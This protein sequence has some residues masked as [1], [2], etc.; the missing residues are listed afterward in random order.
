MGPSKKFII[1]HEWSKIVLREI[2]IA[3]PFPLSGEVRN[4]VLVLGPRHACCFLLPLLVTLLWQS[5]QVHF[6]T[7]F[8]DCTYAQT[9][10]MPLIVLE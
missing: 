6:M 7:A 4:K 1:L 9:R 8:H 3:I 10:A 2:A 5:S